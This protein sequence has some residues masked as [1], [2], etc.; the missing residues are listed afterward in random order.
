MEIIKAT[1]IHRKFGK[2]DLIAHVLKG[3][4]LSIGE[5]E[6]VAI[7]GASGSGKS[8]LLHILGFLDKQTSGTYK[9][10]GKTND[11]YTDEQSAHIRNKQL[12]FVFQMFNLLP[13]T[14]VKENVKLPLL[15]S[16][17][18]AAEWDLKA[19]AAIEAVDL[20]HRID[21]ET[22]QLSG[23]ER[24]RTAIARALVNDPQ[25]IFADEPT[26]NLDTANG[27]QVLDLLISLQKDEGASLVLVS[28]SPEV[29]ARADRVVVM[30]DGVVVE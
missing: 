6:F 3:I 25:I 23:G 19:K 22:S 16:Q 29:V 17:V 21:H 7:M 15:Y 28:H 1:N 18:K 27:E 5:N 11:S 14:S 24:Q 2:G 4:D 26:G 30:R 10:D 13:R 9:L 20:S 12:G 8:T